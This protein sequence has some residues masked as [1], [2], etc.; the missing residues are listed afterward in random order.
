MSKTMQMQ[1]E[2][3]VTQVCA[4]IAPLWPLD[5]FVA[6]NPYWGFMDQ[7]FAQTAVYLSSLCGE[8]LFLDR[9]WFR[10]QW[11]AGKISVEDIQAAAADLGQSLP[12]NEMLRFLKKDQAPELKPL[13]LLSNVLHR[14]NAPA[15]DDFLLDQIGQFLAA[16]YDRGQ[17]SWMRPQ[18]EDEQGLFD[19][20]RQYALRNRSAKVIGIGDIRKILMQVPRN[21]VAAQE[22]ALDILDV[23]GTLLADYLLALLK[24]I[25]GWASWCRY[26][27]WQAE[28]QG[29][30]SSELPELLTIRL[31]W[32]AMLYSLADIEKR[33]LW[34]KKL[35]RW[36]HVDAK[37]LEREMRVREACVRALEKNF[38]QGITRQFH[39]NREQAMLVSN[40]RP[41]LQAAFCIDVRSE[42]FRRHLEAVMEDVQTIGFAG[43]FGVPLQ[44]RREGEYRSRGHLPVLLSAKLTAEESL[45]AAV[46]KKRIGR[47]RRR[48]EWKQFKTAAAS[49][50]S[51][52]ESAG[53]AY[54][55]RMLSESL[56]WQQPS[57]APDHAALTAQELQQV[58]PVL[59]DTV[60]AGGTEAKVSLAERVLRGLGLTENFAPIVLLLGH[61]STTTNNAHRAG[62]D[63]GACAGQTGEVSARVTA[64]LLNDTTLRAGLRERGIDIPADTHFLAG[65]HD[66]SN[67]QVTLYEP[68]SR[69]A[70]SSELH[71]V[72]EA[73][74]Q[75]GDLT[76]LERI[77]KLMPGISDPQQAEKLLN[78]RGKDWSQVRPEWALAGNAAF[79]AA[80]RWR[81]AGANLAGRAFLHDY[82]AAQDPD[83]SVLTL[84]MTAPLVVASWINLQYYGSTVDNLRQGSGN[85]VLHNVVGGLIGVLEGNGG[86]L[87]VGL[88][89]QSLLDGYELRHEPLRLSV[90]IEAPQQAMDGI[91]AAHPLLR[92]M[93]CNRWM[94]LFQIAED[95]S[96]H[97]R[98]PDGGWQLRPL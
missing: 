78:W 70:K 74:R 79:I 73:L 81:T 59:A 65:M 94:T 92:N 61:G 22:W 60:F 95:G 56:G 82:E 96:P 85:K 49:C 91:I 29:G 58:H 57:V 27:V 69:F 14:A 71:E 42:V 8:K 18:T 76:R 25:G 30:T 1:Q 53:M 39:R 89:V 72:K 3:I 11:E 9:S 93:I 6:V 45:P 51:F 4:K 62:L 33:E 28:L 98:Q 36:Q 21:A 50:F 37:D 38:R 24:S 77:S 2:E 40:A 41:S 64:D 87:R 16:Y 10:Q 17:A 55:V 15:I 5:S 46:Q 7:D 26:Q 54:G 44:Y 67:D 90:F 52:V 13:L 47:L 35:R 43:F 86:D 80:P 88:A 20:W 97:E 32:E 31:M 68:K 12:A 83:F 23:P 19:A 66:T 48:A 63:C 75:A 84:I 34:Q